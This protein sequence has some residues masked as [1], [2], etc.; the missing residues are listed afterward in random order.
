M[1]PFQF[2]KR[3]VQ[4]EHAL[5]KLDDPFLSR[6]ITSDLRMQS[7]WCKLRHCEPFRS[8]VRYTPKLLCHH[9][10]LVSEIMAEIFRDSLII[11]KILEYRSFILRKF[12]AI[13]YFHVQNVW[14]FKNCLK[15]VTLIK[16]IKGLMLCVNS[17]NYVYIEQVIRIFV[18]L[19]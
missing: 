19:G 11:C 14:T 12:P 18:A 6:S 3:D 5:L 8:H 15:P 13:Q 10:I 4:M 1:S 17:P 9:H 7:E 16:W 2:L